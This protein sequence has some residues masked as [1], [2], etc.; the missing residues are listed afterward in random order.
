MLGIGLRGVAYRTV[1]RMTGWAAIEDGVRLRF[2]KN[3]SLANGV[4]LDRNVYLHACDKGIRIGEN[5]LVM[6]GAV[7]HVYNFRD[8]PD[9]K[10][11]I[12]RDSLIGEYTVI[13]GQ[14]GV[15]I[16]DRVFTSPY[17]QLIAVNHVYKD[18]TRSFV[19]QGITAQGII[20]EDDVWIGSGAIITD[21][22]RV[23]KGS[24]V[25]AGAVV[26]RDVPSHVVVAGVPAK[27]VKEI[28]ST[29]AAKEDAR[30]VYL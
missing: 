25:A 7:L 30:A 24:V 22:V 4:Y 26:T 27:I 21:G 13:R 10:I 9:A 16:G 8:L 29:S 20:V 12:G 5:T 15:V 23:G 17:S 11:H 3:I 2:P 14:G 18:P 28:D 6:Y 1:M 19:D